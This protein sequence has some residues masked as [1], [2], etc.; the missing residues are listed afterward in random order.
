VISRSARPRLD[1]VA[2]DSNAAASDISQVKDLAVDN[3]PPAL[4]RG[5]SGR[6]AP[7]R[8]DVWV[9]KCDPISDEIAAALAIAGRLELSTPH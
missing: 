5:R 3:Q 1:P 8:T 9:Q 2:S 6:S 7:C 4:R